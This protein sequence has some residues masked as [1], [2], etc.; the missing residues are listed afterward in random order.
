MSPSPGPFQVCRLSV[1]VSGFGRLGPIAQFLAGADLAH[2]LL[3][4]IC[5]FQW[6]ILVAVC[7]H[8]DLEQHHQW[9]RL[10]QGL[11]PSESFCTEAPNLNFNVNLKLNTLI[12][13]PVM[14]IMAT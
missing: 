8:H 7:A 6:P 14:I 2:L 3:W 12:M 10:A 5:R 13:M 9:P 11:E 1:A 4:P